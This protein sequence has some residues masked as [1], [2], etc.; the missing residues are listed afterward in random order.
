MAPI[1]TALRAQPMEHLLLEG[2]PV[3]YEET[4][5]VS[6]AA[7]G[8]LGAA[9]A[10]GASS[11]RVVKLVGHRFGS[12]SAMRAV[13]GGLSGGGCLEE[14]D[15]TNSS[16][17]VE[18][19]AALRGVL[20]GCASSLQVLKLEDCGLEEEGCLAVCV[21]VGG[22]S[23]LRELDLRNNEM[24]A[25]SAAALAKSVWERGSKAPSGAGPSE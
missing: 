18:G 1:A 2:A 6:D 15:L 5:T 9:L 8:A 13:L 4:P 24:E 25:D 3:D 17:G 7:A 10:G 19:G 23:R 16:L 22:L 11:L 21:A 12:A 14:L 20:S